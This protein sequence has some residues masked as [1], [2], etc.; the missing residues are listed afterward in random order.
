M[1]SLYCSFYLCH[2]HICLLELRSNMELK[3]K[4]KLINDILMQTSQTH[5]ENQQEE[6]DREEGSSYGM[7][8][9]SSSQHTHTLR[10]L[11]LPDKD[12]LDKFRELVN[13]YIQADDFKRNLQER[14]REQNALV[15][16]LSQSILMFMAKYNIEDL[17]AT[18][19]VRLRYKKTTINEPLSAKKIKER[20]D[21]NPELFRG[22]SPEEI[23]KELFQRGK[24][25]K[26]SLRRLKRNTLD[27]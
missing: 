27:V 17:K 14:V 4:N 1:M 3:D 24:M 7:E 10:P 16:K 11:N 23:A 9:P 2:N 25:E 15:K 5:H 21:E 8:C 12:T 18:N 19:G 13:G 6:R 20:L 22:K 26:V